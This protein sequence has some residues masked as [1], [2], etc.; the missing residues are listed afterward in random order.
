MPTDPLDLWPD[1]IRVDPLAPAAILQL[2]ATKLGERTGGRLLA[3]VVSTKQRAAPDARHA[4]VVHKFEIVAPRLDGFRCQLFVCHHD[5]DRVYPVYLSDDD[6]ELG[7]DSTEVASTTEKEFIAVVR[8]VFSSKPTRSLIES[9]LARIAEQKAA[10][11][12]A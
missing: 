1:D 4:A 5:A 3:Q 12:P 6:E 8:K 10:P 11:V 7:L 2:Q 9:L